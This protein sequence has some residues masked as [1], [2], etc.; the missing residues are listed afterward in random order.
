[1]L[2]PLDSRDVAVERLH[3]RL[4]QLPRNEWAVGNDG[5]LIELDS[6]DDPLALVAMECL[7]REWFEPSHVR[8]EEAINLLPTKELARGER[9][10]SHHAAADL[11][12]NILS[13]TN[14]ISVSY[15]RY[16]ERTKGEHR[17]L[18]RRVDKGPRWNR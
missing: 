2:S 13:K 6:Q 18:G 8:V 17:D 7:E 14:R 4:C 16:E 10:S 15:D 9:V 1:M 12:A 3:H 5:V 11:A